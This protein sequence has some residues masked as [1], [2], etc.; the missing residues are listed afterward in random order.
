MSKT[1]RVKAQDSKYITRAECHALIVHV[2]NQVFAQ[3]AEEPVE[4]AWSP[5]VAEATPATHADIP[6]VS[7]PSIS[8]SQGVQDDAV[9]MLEVVE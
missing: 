6:T 5:G 8:W 2:I 7:A 9:A 4:P 1:R 3:M